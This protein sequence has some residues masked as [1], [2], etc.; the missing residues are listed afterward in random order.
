[1]REERGGALCRGLGPSTMSPLV[2]DLWT[3]QTAGAV[4]GPRGKGQGKG[5]LKVLTGRAV[6]EL[7]RP[8][9]KQREWWD[10]KWTDRWTDDQAEKNPSQA[11]SPQSK[12]CRTGK[13]RGGQK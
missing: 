6:L 5:Q 3:L 4:G 12:P 11:A 13:G 7:A 2:P 9:G 8:E 1:M 10:V